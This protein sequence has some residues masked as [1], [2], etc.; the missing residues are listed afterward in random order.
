MSKPSPFALRRDIDVFGA[1]AGPA[2]SM[3]ALVPS[4]VRP[5]ASASPVRQTSLS[6]SQYDVMTGDPY[7]QAARREQEMG[8]RLPSSFDTPA[9]QRGSRSL[10]GKLP[11]LH[12]DL[13]GGHAVYD[14]ASVAGMH[15]TFSGTIGNTPNPYYWDDRHRFG[16]AEGGVRGPGFSDRWDVPHAKERTAG[17]LEQTG[18]FDQA[19]R[20]ERPYLQLRARATDPNGPVVQPEASYQGAALVQI[21]AGN[22][23]DGQGVQQRTF[24]L[25]GGFVGA[26]DLQGWNN[27][28]IDVQELLAGTYV[29]FAWTRNGLSGDNRSLYLPDRYTTSATGDPVPEGAYALVIENPTPLVAGNTATVDWISRF[30]GAAF[31]ITQGV[32]D[33]AQMGVGVARPYAF[34]G[35]PIEVYGE[36]FV[37]NHAATNNFDI[38]WLLRPI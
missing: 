18:S 37:I 20:A 28:R 21:T 14:A 22:F 19:V 8:R 5:M 10:A 23:E 4:S 38:M 11:N 7:E 16:Y 3:G 15:T 24:L 27:V 9:A 33:N 35:T 32:S 6:R 29:E 13:S 36:T 12:Q 31:T 25:G 17:R 30:N 26:F 2:P 34:Y 1:V